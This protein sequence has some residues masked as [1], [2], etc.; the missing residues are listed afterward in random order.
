M[1]ETFKK[2]LIRSINNEIRSHKNRILYLE[3]D[4]RDA[5]DITIGFIEALQEEKKKRLEH[6]EKKVCLLIYKGKTGV[7]T[8]EDIARAKQTPIS[9]F[10]KVPQS[11][12]VK[13]LFHDDKVPSMHIYGTTYHC[14]VCEAHGSVVD[15]VM[16]LNGTSFLE[17]V[18]K[19]CG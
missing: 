16:K 4:K 13:C 10:I 19:M 8:D 15:I 9:T 14:F 17:A 11:K 12:K 1:N 5:N 7:I 6:L 18:K 3:V 2:D